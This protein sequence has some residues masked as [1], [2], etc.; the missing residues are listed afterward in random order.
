MSIWSDL[1]K[2]WP[3][4]VYQLKNSRVRERYKFVRDNAE[5]FRNKKVL[6]IGCNAALFATILADKVESYWGLE[7]EGKYFNQ[8]NMTVKKIG[9]Q[10]I[11]VIKTRFGELNHVLDVDALILSRVLYY[12]PDEDIEFL[13]DK[14]LPRCNVVL[15]ICGA[16]EKK[17]RVNSWGFHNIESI[18]TLLKGFEIQHRWSSD[19]KLYMGMATRG[20]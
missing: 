6:D 10:D 17:K 12:L 4:K 13:Q 7:K 5:H 18:F 2:E 1:L 11:R 19:R 20:N 14:Y 8:A 16:I 9:K 15:F 3:G